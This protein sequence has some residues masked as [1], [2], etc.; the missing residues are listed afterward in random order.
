MT[1]RRA[2]SARYCHPELMAGPPRWLSIAAKSAGGEGKT[3]EEIADELEI[4]KSRVQSWFS[5]AGKKC[6]GVREIGTGRWRLVV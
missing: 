6:S 2:A 1:G 3:I 4:L 5:S